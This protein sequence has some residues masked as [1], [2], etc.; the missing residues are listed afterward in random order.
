MI[1]NF[2]KWINLA[3]YRNEPDWRTLIDE[4]HKMFGERPCFANSPEEPPFSDIPYEVLLQKF[5]DGFKNAINSGTKLPS[6]FNVRVI[7]NVEY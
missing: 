1:I 2:G 4:Y 6:S 3:L 7:M 5:K